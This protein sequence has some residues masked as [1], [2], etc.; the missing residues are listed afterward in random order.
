MDFQFFGHTDIGTTR[1]TN[2]DALVIKTAVAG[3]IKVTM[4]AVCDGVGGL[5]QG[6]KA[7]REAVSRL[8][9]WFDYEMPQIIGQEGETDILQNRWEQ[10][11]DEIN[12]K[13]YTFGQQNGISMGTTMTAI[14]IWDRQYFIAHVGDSRAYEI[15]SGVYQITEDH[16]FLAR[17][18]RCGRMT[19]EEARKDGRS[20]L[21]LQCIGA[22]AS[23]EPD[24]LRGNLRDQVTFLLC[25]DG[26][27]HHM[28][29]EELYGFFSPDH[30]TDAKSLRANALMA[31]E[32]VKQRGET[33][34]ISVLVFRISS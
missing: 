32:L 11:I 4:G 27:W 10:L 3:N 14:L 22:R 8:S 12:D 18:V 6:E 15:A 25:S 13:I 24:F 21:I 17:E 16:S 28:G 20:N 30:L 23:V 2:Q 33:D 34:N 1:Q 19:E 7:S 31:A 29:D 5:S 26:F 9:D